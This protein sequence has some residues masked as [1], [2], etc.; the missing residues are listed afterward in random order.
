MP[1]AAAA[2]LPADAAFDA[3]F[4][5]ADAALL[6][7]VAALLA[8][9]PLVIFLLLLLLFI[10]LPPRVAIIYISYIKK[11]KISFPKLNLLNYQIVLVDGQYM[12]SP[13]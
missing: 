2:A 9:L 12:S 5:A 7:L 10:L 8:P 11:I 1:A 3:A 6:A 13:F 4:D